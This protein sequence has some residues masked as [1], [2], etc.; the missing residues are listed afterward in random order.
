M[1]YGDT[2]T[3][4]ASNQQNQQA[5]QAAAVLDDFKP[6]VLFHPETLCPKIDLAESF[7]C[8]S[9]DQEESFLKKKRSK[10]YFSDLI[11]CSFGLLPIPT[12]QEKCD[13]DDDS[14]LVSFNS[15]RNVFD[16]ENL[17]ANTSFKSKIAIVNDN[18]FSKN[19]TLINNETTAQEEEVA[20]IDDEI[21]K[22]KR[23][24][25]KEEDADLEI[26]SEI[27]DGEGEKDEK[28]KKLLYCTHPDC[29]DREPRKYF[30]FP[31]SLRSHSKVHL[32]DHK[33][34]SCNICGHRF[35]RNHDL[36]RHYRN[37]HKSLVLKCSECG[38]VYHT[39]EDFEVHMNTSHP[40]YYEQK[41]EFKRLFD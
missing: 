24:R 13:I 36:N 38:C 7:Q 40:S 27:E 30:K 16:I 15:E 33:P 37:I 10:N 22:K 4:C 6:K 12:T 19:T 17:T 34:F 32:K 21:T 23:K 29:L 2:F 9:L 35:Q 8:F 1:L 11:Q 20:K 18:N 31:F 25:N 26:L 3:Y 41:K 14:S 28:K 5:L 39:N